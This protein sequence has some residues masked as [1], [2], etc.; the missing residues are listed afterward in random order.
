MG[1]RASIYVHFNLSGT[2]QSAHEAF[3]GLNVGRVR[4][5]IGEEM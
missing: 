2:Y 5:M 1:H 4:G 3:L